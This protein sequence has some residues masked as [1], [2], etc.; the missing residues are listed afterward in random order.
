MGS[1][2]WSVVSGW[3]VVER[4]GKIM[5]KGAGG[6]FWICDWGFWTVAGGGAWESCVPDALLQIARAKPAGL[7]E[8]MLLKRF[9]RD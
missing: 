4:N 9:E 1:S 5:G 7:L 8:S 2:Q 3:G 6:G